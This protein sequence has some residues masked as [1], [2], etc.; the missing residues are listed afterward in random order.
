MGRNDVVF[1]GTRIRF[2][3]R[4][5]GHP[6]VR[7]S[8]WDKENLFN[9]RPIK[10]TSS[11]SNAPKSL[12]PGILKSALYRAATNI[13]N[14]FDLY[15]EIE[16]VIY[17]LRSR[18]YSKNSLFPQFKDFV[19]GTYWDF[20]KQRDS[21]HH[22]FFETN[23]RYDNGKSVTAEKE[24]IQQHYKVIGRNDIYNLLLN[25]GIPYAKLKRSDNT[26]VTTFIIASQTMIKNV[27]GCEK[28]KA[29]VNE[30]TETLINE[31]SIKY[32]VGIFKTNK[33]SN[34]FKKIIPINVSILSYDKGK[35]TREVI[36]R[37][38]EHDC[39]MLIGCTPG[40]YYFPI[41]EM[42]NDTD[43]QNLFF[44]DST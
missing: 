31:L 4:P 17:R 37:D 7:L 2:E 44:K 8:I 5:R 34:E 3:E 39:H 40:G 18:G 28:C 20:P 30:N 11:A 25:K 24:T 23:R 16:K 6:F 32:R 38:D 29:N 36:N 14:D 9:F 27:A 42:Y 15:L 10:Y 35:T 21:L 1:L 22:H 19:L 43:I 12:G 33:F 41:T 13:N 26:M